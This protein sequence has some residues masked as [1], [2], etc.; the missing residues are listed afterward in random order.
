MIM[1]FIQLLVEQCF[2]SVFLLNILGIFVLLGRNKINSIATLE[3]NLV[4]RRFLS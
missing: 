3:E 4:M 1:G 2:S